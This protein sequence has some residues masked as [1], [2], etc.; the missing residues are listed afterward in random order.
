M[1][2]FSQL[3]RDETG[4]ILSAEAVTVGTVTVVG[5]TVGLKMTADSVNDELGEMAQAFRGLDQS[6]SVKGYRSDRAWTASSGYQ[7]PALEN[8][9]VVPQ[10]F[11]PNLDYQP[12]E[13]PATEADSQT[14]A[15]AP[16]PK[17]LPEYRP[18]SKFAEETL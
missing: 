13:Q 17:R 6:Y 11:V 7:Q 16:K 12:E 18:K 10:D 5:A 14:S 2:L 3:W 8:A 1:Q 9:D 15:P 4:A